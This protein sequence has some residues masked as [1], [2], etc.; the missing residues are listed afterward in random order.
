MFSLNDS[1]SDPSRFIFTLQPQAKFLVEIQTKVLRVFL[2]LCLRY[3]FLQTHATS[4]SFYYQYRFSEPEQ[5]K[6]TMGVSSITVTWRNRATAWASQQLT[7]GFTS[8]LQSPRYIMYTL[9]RSVPFLLCT[10]K[11]QF[12]CLDRSLFFLSISLLPPLESQNIL[13]RDESVSSVSFSFSLWADLF[14]LNLWTGQFFSLWTNRFLSHWTYLFPLSLDCL[15]PFLSGY[16]SF[17]SLWT[18]QV[19]FLSLLTA[20][21]HFSLDKSLLFLSGKVCVLSY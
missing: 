2:L 13:F 3:L 12:P 14:P 10:R 20:L 11:D 9:V 18:S 8:P 17:L 16:T 6:L 1:I 7:G 19:S 4:Y 21:F 5:R 15:V